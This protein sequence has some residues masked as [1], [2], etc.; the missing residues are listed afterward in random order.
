MKGKNKGNKEME[1]SNRGWICK[2]ATDFFRDLYR[3]TELSI[4][5]QSSNLEEVPHILEG[6]TMK[7]ILSQKTIKPLV[8]TE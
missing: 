3:S 6:E 8:R 1:T 4:S 5:A 7:A 2:I